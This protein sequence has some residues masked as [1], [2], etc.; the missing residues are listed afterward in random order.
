MPDQSSLGPPSSTSAPSASEGL[1]RLR[2]LLIQLPLIARRRGAAASA[3][4]RPRHDLA[5]P[6]SACAPKHAACPRRPPALHSLLS[7]RPRCTA[8]FSN[9]VRT[10]LTPLGR[11][12]DGWSDGRSDNRSDSRAIGRSADRSAGRAV[13]LSSAT[14]SMSALPGSASAS[15]S[16]QPSSAGVGAGVGIGISDAMSWPV[17]V[18]HVISCAGVN[19]FIAIGARVSASTSGAWCWCRRRRWCCC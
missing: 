14:A 10:W 7:R 12:S 19:R 1:A 13:A 16:A 6:S 18:R 8:L 15:A 4:F 9:L 2:L 3:A 11:E 5:G 17:V